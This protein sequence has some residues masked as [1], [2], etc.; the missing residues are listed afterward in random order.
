MT[1]PVLPPP[2]TKDWTFVMAGG[3]PEC[4]FRPVIEPHTIAARIRAT[5]PRW[6]TALARPDAAVRPQPDVWS[7]LEYDCHVRD[8]FDLFAVRL[9]LMLA[10]DLAR[11]ENWDQD[12]TAIEER[13]WEQAPAVVAAELTGAGEA[14][15]AAY[16]A[17]PDA[18]WQ[19][20]GVR[21]NG[22]EFTIATFGA[23]LLHDVEHH[24]H[25]VAA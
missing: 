25:D 24:L 1:D 4:G 8:V 20:R 5:I 17:V 19:H 9:G 10:T 12:A 13:Y 22:A 6:R 18:A 3:C 14:L 7:P 15:A 16:D 23:Y 11:F 2:D 21:S